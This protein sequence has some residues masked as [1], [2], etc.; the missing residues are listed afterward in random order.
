M[1]EKTALPEYADTLAAFHRAFRRELCRAVRA[2]PLTSGAAVLDVP[3]GD[4][5]YS[6]LLARRLRP[7]GKVTAAD[8]SDSY[9]SAAR[10][11]VAAVGDS[12]AVEFV[13]ADAYHL[14]FD[15]AAFDVTWCAQSFISLE[16][17]VRALMEMRRVTRP[18]GSVAVLEDDDLHRVVLNWPVELEMELRR[19]AVA[20]SAAKYGSRAALSPARRMRQFLSDAGL[21]PRGK[22][23]IAADRLAPFGP[24]VRR[25]LRLHLRDTRAYLTD[26]LKPAALAAL[27]R[28]ID[29]DHPES[30]LKR[31]DATVTCL[32][33]LFIAGR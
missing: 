17:P 28:A 5:F 20:A 26:F 18:G 7:F 11:A 3:C 4:G 32:T 15:D 1:S 27:D 25:F 33:T 21:T 16:D 30:L 23:T 10:T 6:A 12:A 29:P 31:P 19:A 9:L 22:K 13:K 8:R 14:P 24:A 2:V